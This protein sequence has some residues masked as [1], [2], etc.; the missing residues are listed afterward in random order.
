MVIAIVLQHALLHVHSSAQ[1][2]CRDIDCVASF[3]LSPTPIR[4][5]SGRIAPSRYLVIGQPFKAQDPKTGWQVASRQSRRIQVDSADTVDSGRGP[6]SAVLR[7]RSRMTLRDRTQIPGS[8]S[9]RESKG[10]NHK[11][12]FKRASNKPCQP[13]SSVMCDHL[14]D[15]SSV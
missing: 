1:L 13:T 4:P 8:A 5:G 10:R 11:T 9:R 15:G 14:S 7:G 2:N 3:F 6:R 12:W